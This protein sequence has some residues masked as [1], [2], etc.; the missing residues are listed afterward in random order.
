VPPLEQ[1]L[2][3]MGAEEAGAAGDDASAHTRA[4]IASPRARPATAKTGAKP[5]AAFVGRVQG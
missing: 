3:E 4:R 2:A 5:R 1:L